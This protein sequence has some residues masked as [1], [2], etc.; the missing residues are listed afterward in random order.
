MRCPHCGVQSSDSEGGSQSC[1]CLKSL[2]AMVATRS[3][4]GRIRVRRKSQWTGALFAIHV[5]VDGKKVGSLRPG[6]EKCFEVPPGAHRLQMVQGFG[7]S[8]PTEVQLQKHQE[9]LLETGI[10]WYGGPLRWA[11]SGPRP[12][13]KRTGDRSA[14][15]QAPHRTQEQATGPSRLLAALLAFIFG[16]L[17]FHKFYLGRPGLGVLYLLLC[18]TGISAVLG[19]LEALGFLCMSNAAFA[20]K[21]RYPD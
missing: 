21:Y 8:P 17:G 4:E 13:L 1:S 3:S 12:Y 20:N 18:W 6:E 5:R 9:V 7:K 15:G 11:F 16:A 10:E 14:A 2:A 19:M